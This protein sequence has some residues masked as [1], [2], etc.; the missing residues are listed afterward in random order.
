MERPCAASTTSG[1][2]DYIGQ[3]SSRAERLR[4]SDNTN[5]WCVVEVERNVGSSDDPEWRLFSAETEE[6]AV[7]VDTAVAPVPL[8]SH[9]GLLVYQSLKN[10]IGLGR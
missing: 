1:P 10:C 6:A 8:P 2:A 5:A 4:F 3:G 7:H 9:S